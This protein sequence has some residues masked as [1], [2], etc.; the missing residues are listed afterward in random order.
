MSKNKL[1]E[2]QGYLEDRDQYAQERE[3]ETVAKYIDELRYLVESISDYKKNPYQEELPD[4][5]SAKRLINQFQN[6]NEK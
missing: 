3:R 4:L 5:Y 1:Q 2:L 6:R